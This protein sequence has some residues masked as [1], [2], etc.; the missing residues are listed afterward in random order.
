MEEA[1][2]AE[3]QEIERKAE[4]QRTEA[5]ERAQAQR[6][7]MEARVEAQ[8]LEFAQKL[9]E[10]RQTLEEQHQSYQRKMEASFQRQIAQA[11][12]SHFP[13]SPVPSPPVVLIP[14]DVTRRMENQD[15]RIQ[16]LTDMI[17]QLVTRSPPD[18]QPT[19]ARASTGKRHAPHEVLDLTLDREIDDCASTQSR[20][21]RQDQGAKKQDTKETPR[22]NLAGNISIKME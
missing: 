4:Q 9:E 11:I 21:L 18:A 16:Q 20:M 5:E 8:R 12:Q 14:D 22:Q 19:T 15:A 2:Q 7:E 13:A 6:N 3:I 17:Q 10:Q 1:N